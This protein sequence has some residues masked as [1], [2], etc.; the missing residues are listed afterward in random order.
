MFNSVGI[1]VHL[2]TAGDRKYNGKCIHPWCI[3]Y[4]NVL[5]D[6]RR[7]LFI[8]L[9]NPSHT[10]ETIET[11]RFPFGCATCNHKPQVAVS[12][13]NFAAA[14]K[15]VHLDWRLH[16]TLRGRCES[17]RTCKLVNRDLSNRSLHPL[18]FSSTGFSSVANTALSLVATES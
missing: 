7:V 16:G 1:Y 9:R 15:M 14:G 13:L 11:F 18:P 17:L 5:Y 6:L 12:R 4:S 2:Y 10:N 3:C 8:L